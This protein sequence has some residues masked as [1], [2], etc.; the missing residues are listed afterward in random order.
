LPT[1]AVP[2][3]VVHGARDQRTEPGEVDALAA[4]LSAGAAPSSDPAAA[5][6]RHRIAVL[7]VGGHSPHSESAT[8]DA[9]TALARAF[10]S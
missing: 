10:F 1:L 6:R 8:A 3:L 5:R 7:D 2:I 9:V 4:A